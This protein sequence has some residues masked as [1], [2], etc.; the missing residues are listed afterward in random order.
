MPLIVD[1]RGLEGI[2]GYK[3]KERGSPRK[4]IDST[5]TY[6]LERA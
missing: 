1:L 5:I 4:K 2:K 6:A 3:P